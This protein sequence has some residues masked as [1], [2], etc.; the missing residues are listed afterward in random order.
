M[1]S[2]VKLAV[3]WLN[4]L[5]LKD[6]PKPV[7]LLISYPMKKYEEKNVISHV[8]VYQ[9]YKKPCRNLG[10]CKIYL[11]KHVYIRTEIYLFL[12]FSSNFVCVCKD[13][14]IWRKKC[15]EL[16]KEGMSEI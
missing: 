5:M 3:Y 8:K 12:Y 13:Q 11:H 16:G 1:W 7:Q 4:S 2:I 6:S 10:K 14:Q 15:D 9:K